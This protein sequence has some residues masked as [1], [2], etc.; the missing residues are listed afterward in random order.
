[1]NKDNNDRII[2][3]Q[4][5]SRPFISSVMESISDNGAGIGR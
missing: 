5:M 1:M 4:T 2:D 3:E